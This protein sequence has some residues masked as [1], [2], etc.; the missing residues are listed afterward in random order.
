MPSNNDKK[1][2][3]EPWADWGKLFKHPTTG[4]IKIKRIIK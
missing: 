4:V 3:K 2:V 1:P